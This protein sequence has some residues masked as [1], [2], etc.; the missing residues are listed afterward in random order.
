MPEDPLDSPAH[1]FGRVAAHLDGLLIDADF[2]RQN[3][4]VVVR[5]PGLRN[6]V[7]EP[8]QSGGVAHVGKSQCLWIGP[9]IDDDLDVVQFVLEFLG[10]L[11]EGLGY[12]MFEG[13]TIH[14]DIL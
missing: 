4:P 5:A 12:Q 13:V 6:A 9:I 1:L 11:V 10:Q 2:V 14:T 7:V 8:Q 3:Q